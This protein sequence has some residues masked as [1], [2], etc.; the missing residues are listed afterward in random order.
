MEDY[1][2]EEDGIILSDKH[3]VNASVEMCMLCG[4]ALGIIMF[5]KLPN[6]EKAPDEVCLGHI[7]DKCNTK[8]EEE[9]KHLFIE[10]GDKPTG[11]YAKIPDK[12]L[13]P[14]FVEENKNQ[15]VFNVEPKMFDKLFNNE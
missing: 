5:G 6:D 14:S 8:L 4:E 1:V 2:K 12:Y 11:R 3:G 7:C 10:F 13:V 9:E 15:R